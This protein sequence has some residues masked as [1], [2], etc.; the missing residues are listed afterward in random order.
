MKG[1]ELKVID[2]EKKIDKEIHTLYVY[3]V[4]KDLKYGN[5]YAIY[6]DNN[7]I[8]NDVLHYAGTHFKGDTLVLLN[9]KEVNKVEEMV[10]EF[11]WN[12]YNDK[13]NTNYEM[14][15]ISSL[16]K[17]EIISSNTITVKDEVINT[18]TKKLIPKKKDDPSLLKPL[19]SSSTKILIRGFSL[20][21][22][23][24]VI[25]YFVNKD[26]LFKE[27]T[28]TVICNKKDVL[29]DINASEDR[30]DTFI[31]NSEKKLLTR[32]VNIKY[33]F[34]DSNSYTEY[35]QL[36]LYYKYEPL[37]SSSEIEY[38]NDDVNNTF[39]IIE[40]AK[41]ETEYFEPT[42]YDEVLERMAY[43]TYTCNVVEEDK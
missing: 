18:L 11:T 30:N 3:A 29:E 6:K 13:E 37:V 28:I 8:T 38:V 12:I 40:H 1:K 36:G 26:E 31:F 16:N 20:A 24:V 34:N 14:L 2:L 41:T 39:T 19:I 33:T 15:D 32:T 7:D 23:V 5:I 4:F 27:E 17:A 35:K 25:F 22:L 21:L 42:N 9:V 10:K 43:Y